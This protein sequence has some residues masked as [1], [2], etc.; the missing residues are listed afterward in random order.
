MTHAFRKHWLKISALVIGGFGPL[1]TLA[2]MP[3]LSEPARWS[4]DLLAY[5]LDGFPSYEAPEM[6]FLSALTGG[7]LVGW[8]VIVWC[9]SLWVYDAC[10]DGVRRCVVTSALAWF[11]LDSLGSVTSEQ[12]PN[13][14]WNILVLLLVIGPLWR[15]AQP[16][17]TP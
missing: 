7:F 2:T 11:A 9:L 14:L 10:P 3:A 8:G 16:E 12:W 4:L 1:L 17:T 6:W 13:A 15:P 5:P